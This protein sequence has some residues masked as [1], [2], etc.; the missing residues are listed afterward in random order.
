MC[1]MFMPGVHVLLT[2]VLYGQNSADTHS[3]TPSKNV[4]FMRQKRF[5]N[6]EFSPSGTS[7]G[8]D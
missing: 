1:L 2:L 6:E 3:N 5:K 4:F 8:K 7:S